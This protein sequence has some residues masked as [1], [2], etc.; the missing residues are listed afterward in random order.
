MKS[1]TSLVL[2]AAVVAT[3]ALAADCNGSHALDRC[4]IGTWQYGSGGSADWMARNIHGAHVTG[5]THNDL[6]LT[7]AG[8][9]TFS[10]GH[11]DIKASAT[12]NMSGMS[13]TGHSVGAATGTWSAT[14]GKFSLCTTGVRTTVTMM[15]HGHPVTITP[16]APTHPQQTAYTCNAIAL[17][18]TQPIPGHEPI[19]TTYRRSR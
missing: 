2:V 11:V 9:G 10:T 12:S 5:V 4:L 14:G 13:A 1:L 8:D 7:F 16:P 17:T 3:P 18:T 15:I 6:R 19:V